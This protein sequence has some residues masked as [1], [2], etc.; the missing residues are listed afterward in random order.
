MAIDTRDKRASVIG[1]GLFNGSPWPIPDTTVLAAE[2]RALG[3]IYSGV[4]IN[5]DWTIRASMV[6]VNL[7]WMRPMEYPEGFISP[8][9]RQMV[10]GLYHENAAVAPGGTVI[11]GSHTIVRAILRG[12]WRGM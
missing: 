2:R 9:D 1:Y 12:L 4:A 8:K 5:V 3:D 7:G 11:T 10:A 6:N